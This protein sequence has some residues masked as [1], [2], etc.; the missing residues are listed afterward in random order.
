[1]STEHVP[2]D[3][4]DK[5]LA[6]KEF[7]TQTHLQNCQLTKNFIIMQALSNINLRMVVRVF[8]SSLC[9][10]NA[11]NFSQVLHLQYF[12]KQITLPPPPP[13]WEMI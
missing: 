3:S 13:F 10:L 12:R 5:K 4:K 1:M 8:G 9:I 2:T 11:L 7:K 6:L